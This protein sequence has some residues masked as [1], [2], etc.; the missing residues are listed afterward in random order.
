MLARHRIALIQ[1][2]ADP[3]TSAEHT[4]ACLDFHLLRVMRLDDKD[5]LSDEGRERRGV[6]ARHARWGVNNNVSIGKTPRHFG[7]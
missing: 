7:H 1:E 4:Q 2:K 5:N 3:R 6:A